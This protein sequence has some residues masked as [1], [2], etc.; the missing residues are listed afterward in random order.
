MTSQN[1]PGLHSFKSEATIKSLGRPGDEAS[2]IYPL[3]YQS[4]PSTLDIRIH[5][6][7]LSHVVFGIM[8]GAKHMV[9]KDTTWDT[10]HPK[11]GNV[12]GVYGVNRL[13]RHGYANH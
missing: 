2:L 9:K 6:Y 11:H 7:L 8:R 10:L 12:T 1:R 13:V 5:A 4:M 3:A